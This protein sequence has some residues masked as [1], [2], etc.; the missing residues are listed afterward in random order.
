M[1][2]SKILKSI[3]ASI[4]VCILS[5]FVFAG[6]GTEGG[7][8]VQAILFVKDVY[9]VDYNVETF[10][11]YKV[12]PATSSSYIVSFSLG[13]DYIT[14]SQY[15]RFENGS[16][17]VLDKRFTSIVVNVKINELQDSCEVKLREYPSEI[18]FLNSSEKL[19]ENG[20]K[21]LEVTGVFESETEPRKCKPDEFN[22]K[23]TSSNPSVVEVLDSQN[24]L[25]AS[26]GKAGESDITV[27]ILNSA[28]ES[29]N[30]VA[31]TKIVCENNIS[32]SF[33][34]FGKNVVKNNAEINLVTKLGSQFVTAVKYFDDDQFLIESSGFLVLL[35]NE[36]V[37]K[38]SE[39]NG[40]RVLTVK[41]EGTVTI[42]LQSTGINKDKVPSKITFKVNVQFSA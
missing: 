40:K 8:A 30:L 37:L 35:S 3:I 34:V 25:V 32:D 9:Y 15:F 5:L 20:V 14:E 22:Y 27:E 1:K 39:E 21:T 24:L 13:S 26:T 17:K 16:V 28:G 38:L 4:A 23:I 2:K 29:Q 6:C 31:T 10:L 42:I 12:Y 19:Y 36:N 7:S 33:A 41:G 11:D 18:A